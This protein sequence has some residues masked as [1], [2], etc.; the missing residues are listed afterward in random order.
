[1]WARDTEEVE[2]K[3]GEKAGK[4]NQWPSYGW[5]DEQQKEKRRDWARLT[6]K[7]GRD[8]R[9]TCQNNS[10]QKEKLTNYVSDRH[11]K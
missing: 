4:M 8:D 9:F 7:S 10:K 3:V 2:K 6:G 1:M 11:S 5:T